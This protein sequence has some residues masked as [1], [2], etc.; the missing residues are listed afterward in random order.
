MRFA[1]GIDFGTTNS[2]I[3][4]MGPAGTPTVVTNAEGDP[5][6]PSVVVFQDFGMADEPLVGL[7][8]KHLVAAAP[9]E[10]VCDVKRHMGNPTWVFDS[11]AGHR[12][13]AE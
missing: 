1:V 8:A 6:T 3:A 9:D 13:G 2:A 10:A 12:Y 4:V 11:P 7:M 5:T